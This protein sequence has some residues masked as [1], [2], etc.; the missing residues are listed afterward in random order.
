MVVFS[1]VVL[2]PASAYDVVVV[3]VV[4][5]FCMMLSACDYFF[6]MSIELVESVLSFVF[7]VVSIGF[8]VCAVLML[9]YVAM[10]VEFFWV[11]DV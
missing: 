3:V 9:S 8:Y 10:V 5:L 7:S 6:A 2:I 4:A 1:T 11:F